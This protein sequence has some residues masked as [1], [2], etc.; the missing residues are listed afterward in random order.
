MIELYDFVKNVQHKKKRNPKTLNTFLEEKGFIKI[1]SS[2][3]KL[4]RLDLYDAEKSN[5]IKFKSD[6]VYLTKNGIEYKGY[7]YLKT[8]WIERYSDYPKFHITNCSTV[9]EINKRKDF[10]W[11]NSNEAEI[12]DR[13]SHKMYNKNLELCLNCRKETMSNIISTQEFYDSIEKDEVIKEDVLLDLNG[14]VKGW[15]GNRG[16]SNTYKKSKNFKC[17]SCSIQ[18]IGSD[19]RFIDT[20]HID[21]NKQNN[22][23]DDS[24]FRCLCKLCHCYKDEHHRQ[25]FGKRRMKREL[26]AFVNKYRSELQTLKNRYLDLFDKDNE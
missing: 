8:Y 18:L 12:Q 17:E 25:N 20:D 22:P 4:M 5:S 6:G 10:V 19:K 15:L 9:A 1:A 23:K 2:A 7:M 24:N 14:Y 26:T 3:F 11:H 21:G 16:I 13:T